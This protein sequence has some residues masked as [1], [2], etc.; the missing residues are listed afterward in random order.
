M[1][2]LTARVGMRRSCTCTPPTT[3]RRCR[4]PR[5]SLRLP[6]QSLRLPQ[7]SLRVLQSRVRANRNLADLYLNLLNLNL[8]RRSSPGRM[9]NLNLNPRCMQTLTLS[10]R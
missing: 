8:N 9:P 2:R 5:S 1:H 4:V 3:L 7:S 10:Q 6:E